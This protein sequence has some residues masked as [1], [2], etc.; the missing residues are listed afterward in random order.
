MVYMQGLSPHTQHFLQSTVWNS[1]FVI[2]S[3]YMMMLYCIFFIL[4]LKPFEETKYSISFVLLDNLMIRVLCLESGYEDL[5][6]IAQGWKFREYYG[7]FGNSDLFYVCDVQE[8][9][10]LCLEI[11]SVLSLIIFSCFNKNK[12]NIFINFI[13]LKIIVNIN[14][15]LNFK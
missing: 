4:Q 12:F 8:F 1:K 14:N 5:Y 10:R 11:Q 2:I 9:N 6:F 3:R 13:Y 7:F 15:R